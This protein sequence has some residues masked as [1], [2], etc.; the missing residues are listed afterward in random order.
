METKITI[1]GKELKV[2]LS[3]RN[4]MVY[5][6]I[7]GYA[8]MITLEDKIVYIYATLLVHNES[9][10]MTFDEFINALDEDQSILNQF[11]ELYKTLDKPEEV[12]TE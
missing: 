12:K 1:N 7:R 8:E 10:E 2:K 11:A 5:E 9:L 6:R 4:H 3:L